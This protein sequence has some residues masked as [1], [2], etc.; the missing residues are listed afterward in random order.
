MLQDCTTNCQFCVFMIT[1]IWNGGCVLVREPAFLN[2]EMPPSSHNLRPS[3][4]YISAYLHVI[5]KIPAACSSETFVPTYENTQ[6]ASQKAITFI[7]T[8]GANLYLYLLLILDW[9]FNIATRE[10]ISLLVDCHLHCCYVCWLVSFIM[11]SVG[12]LHYLTQ[13]VGT[14]LNLKMEKPCFSETLVYIY[15]TTFC[16]DTKEHDLNTNHAENLKSYCLIHE[17]KGKITV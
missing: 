12:L 3:V 11:G 5:L 6:N 17:G 15:Q 16:H 7:R 8:G 1:V 10:F 13:Q 14:F 2:K 9:N 4:V